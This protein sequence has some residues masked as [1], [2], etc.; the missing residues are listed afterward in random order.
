M[1]SFD[2]D[3]PNRKDKRRQYHG[4]KAI[5]PSCRPGGSCPWCQSGR[6]HKHKKRE[7][8]AREQMEDRNGE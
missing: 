8:A 1:S 5:D 7:Q 2:K 3:Y 4:S 6:K